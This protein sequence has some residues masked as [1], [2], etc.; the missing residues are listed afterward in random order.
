MSLCIDDLVPDFCNGK[1]QI[2]LDSAHVTDFPNSKCY[3]WKCSEYDWTH[4]Y[5]RED[6]INGGIACAIRQSGGE[7]SCPGKVEGDYMVNAYDPEQPGDHRLRGFQASGTADEPCPDT[8]RTPIP[9]PPSPVNPSP[10]HHPYHP[11]PA[12][13]PHPH[14]P[15]R[16]RHHRHPS[17]PPLPA[18]NCFGCKASGA[19]WAC[20][21]CE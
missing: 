3:T 16:P 18:S 19:G 7:S 20:V 4:S 10:A 13:H 15:H 17:P 21:S 2:P 8:G 14:H 6:K 11:S 9:R 1:M 12:H 5:C